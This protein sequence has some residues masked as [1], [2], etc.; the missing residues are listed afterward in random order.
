MG[1]FKLKAKKSLN[2]KRE[3]SSDLIQEENMDLGLGNSWTWQLEREKT[4]V[5]QK[6]Q[7]HKVITV[8]VIVIIIA[9]EK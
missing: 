6:G 3:Q 5:I 4:R 8:I 7:D 1:V 9:N 2:V